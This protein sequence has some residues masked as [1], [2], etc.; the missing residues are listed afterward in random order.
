M[1]Y[2]P[3]VLYSLE[4]GSLHLSYM[5]SFRISYQ[6]LIRMLLQDQLYYT[7]EWTKENGIWFNF[8]PESYFAGRSYIFKVWVACINISS[9]AVQ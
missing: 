1:N 2:L 5:H 7:W 8:S 3:F 6:C 9:N 4:L